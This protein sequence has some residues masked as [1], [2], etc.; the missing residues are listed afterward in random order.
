VAA[1][2]EGDGSADE[3]GFENDSQ[4]SDDSDDSDDSSSNDSDV[5]SSTNSEETEMVEYYLRAQKRRRQMV[6]V[7]SIVGMYHHEFYMNKIEY[8]VPPKTGY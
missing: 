2:E 7:A 4:D 6:I 1:I 5:S 8:R 3:H